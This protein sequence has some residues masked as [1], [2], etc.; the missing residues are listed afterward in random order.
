MTSNRS[1]RTTERAAAFCAALSETCNIGRACKAIGMGRTT[2][3]EWREAD[4]EFAA[5]W[6]RA[7][8][9]GVTALEDEAHRRAFDGV[10][11]PVVHQGQFTYELEVAKDEQGDTIRNEDGSPQMRIARDPTGKPKHAT[12]QKYSDTL[13]IFLLKAHAPD[14]Y[15]E[16]SKLELSGSLELRKLTDAEI[17]EELAQLGAV[18]AAQA[19]LPDDGSDLV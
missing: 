9:V 5:M 17:D 6:D 2:A 15:R 19:G 11:D 10:S 13:A 14:K 1:N 7:M 18:S 4:E 12:V 8:K 3:Y 16:N